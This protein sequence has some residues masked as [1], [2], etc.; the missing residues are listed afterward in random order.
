MYVFMGPILTNGEYI[1]VM[2]VYIYLKSIS[3]MGIRGS[4]EDDVLHVRERTNCVEHEPPTVLTLYA[5]HGVT[6]LLA[7]L[8][9]H[10]CGLPCF[11]LMIAS[12]S[13]RRPQRRPVE[14]PDGKHELVQSPLDVGHGA[15]VYASCQ[16]PFVLELFVAVVGL[17]V[18]R[19]EA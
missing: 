15:L 11:L 19:P 12:Q 13:Q 2:Y 5:H 1:Y 7:A 6:L 8:D 14:V 4:M 9:P 18:I 3:V 16:K 10:R 17:V